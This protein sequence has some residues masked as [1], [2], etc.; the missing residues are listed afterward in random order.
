MLF[1]QTTYTVYGGSDISDT[2]NAYETGRLIM[3]YSF[4]DEE[5]TDTT[6]SLLLGFS[7]LQEDIYAGGFQPS[8]DMEKCTHL[9]KYELNDIK[10]R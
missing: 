6:A 1:C 3:F 2:L 7:D 9:L 5:T 10:S 4:K 8:L